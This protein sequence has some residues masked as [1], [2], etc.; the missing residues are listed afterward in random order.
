[1]ASKQESESKGFEESLPDTEVMQRHM[2]Q[3]VFDAFR[4]YKQEQEK[5]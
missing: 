1:M 3:S 4:R 2:A 5:N